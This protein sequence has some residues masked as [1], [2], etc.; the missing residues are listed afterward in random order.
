MN[1]VILGSLTETKVIAEEVERQTA[2]RCEQMPLTPNISDSL[3]KNYWHLI[4]MAVNY[5]NLATACTTLYTIK[6]ASPESQVILIS[7]KK[8][9]ELMSSALDTGV[10]HFL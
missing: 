6:E 2:Q 7:S 1:I 3:Q 8:D 9:V 10:S 4:I 5:E